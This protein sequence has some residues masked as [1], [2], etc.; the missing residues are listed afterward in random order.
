VLV[1]DEDDNALAA[2]L[3]REFPRSSLT[4]RKSIPAAWRAAIQHCDKEDPLLST[5]RIRLR[6][7]VFQARLWHT[8]FQLRDQR[9]CL[10][11]ADSGT[12]DQAVACPNADTSSS[13]AVSWWNVDQFDER[14]KGVEV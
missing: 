14:A 4:K 8:L 13:S 9:P 2:A 1:K 6:R 12:Q 5:L 10:P 3:A 11:T 7:D